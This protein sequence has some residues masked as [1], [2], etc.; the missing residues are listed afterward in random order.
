MPKILLIY[1]KDKGLA[2]RLPRVGIPAVDRHHGCRV[3]RV[4]LSRQFCRQHSAAGR[5]D[6]GHRQRPGGQGPPGADRPQAHV[7][8]LALRRYAHIPDI[9]YISFRQ[10][11]HLAQHRIRPGAA[12]AEQSPLHDDDGIFHPAGG[13]APALVLRPGGRHGLGPV[14]L[15]RHHHRRRASVEIHRP[16]IHPAHHRRPGAVLPREI[17]VRRGTHGH[18]RHAPARRQPSP[19]ELLLCLRHGRA[20]HSLAGRGAA[21]QTAAPLAHGLG[22]NRRRRSARP[23]RK[24]PGPVQYL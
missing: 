3:Y 11:L 6:A 16:G 17:R 10:P 4:F 22:R 19:D 13:Y 21:Q 5:H 23:G 9:A 7:D 15:L 14:V 2:A 18:I 8:Q 24:S 20:G 12:G 1:G